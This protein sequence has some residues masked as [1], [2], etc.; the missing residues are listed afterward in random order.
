MSAGPATVADPRE[1]SPE[2]T[3]ARRPGYEDVHDAC[4]RLRDIPLPHSVGLLPLV[5]RCGC[6]CHRPP[7]AVGSR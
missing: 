3:L 2:C 5:R 6:T 4:R 7:T 1:L